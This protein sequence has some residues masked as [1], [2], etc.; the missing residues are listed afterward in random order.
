MQMR[1]IVHVPTRMD[2]LALIRACTSVQEAE[3]VPT[4][5]TLAELVRLQE[6]V[7]SALSEVVNSDG[8]DAGS[9]ER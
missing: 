1:Q 4:Q 8:A 6:K 5:A 2:V 7:W 9:A 3:A